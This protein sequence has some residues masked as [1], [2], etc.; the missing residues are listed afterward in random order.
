MRYF[1]ELRQIYFSFEPS[2]AAAAAAAATKYLRESTCAQSNLFIFRGLDRGG[3][4]I[5]F[6]IF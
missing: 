2:A 3:F 6:S 1:L 5:F 4:R